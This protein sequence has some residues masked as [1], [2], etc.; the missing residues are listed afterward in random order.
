MACGDS[1]LVCIFVSRVGSF[2]RLGVVVGD[3]VCLSSPG[4]EAF[5]EMPFLFLGQTVFGCRCF[6]FSEY[7]RRG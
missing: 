2:S 7:V 6:S 3:V 4:N 5:S 1:Y